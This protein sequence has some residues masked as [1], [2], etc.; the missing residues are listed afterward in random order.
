MNQRKKNKELEN[1][2]KKEIFNLTNEYNVKN[3]NILF[4]LKNQIRNKE[5]ENIKLKITLKDKEENI[6]SL[7]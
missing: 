6:E 5:D 4:D 1:K 2:Y 7:E 3:E